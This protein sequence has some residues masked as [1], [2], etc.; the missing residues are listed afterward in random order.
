MSSPPREPILQTWQQQAFAFGMSA[1]L[2]L[3]GVLISLWLLSQG[4]RREGL[5]ALAAAVIGAVAWWAL[6]G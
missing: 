3:V 1:L 2:P 6:I 4:A 5:F